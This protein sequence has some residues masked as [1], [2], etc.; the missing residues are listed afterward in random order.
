M[1]P[2]KTY[3]RRKYPHKSHQLLGYLLNWSLYGF[4]I[5]Q[6][7]NY[8]ISFP[9]ERVSHAWTARLVYTIFLLDTTQILMTT[10]H[11]WYALIAG[12]G[13]TRAL[14]DP[15]NS[16]I[17]VPLFTSISMLQECERRTA[18]DKCASL[19]YGTTL[20]RLED[21]AARNLQLDRLPRLVNSPSY[22][23]A[24]PPLYPSR[25]SL[26]VFQAVSGI[27]FAA[28]IQVLSDFSRVREIA[29]TATLWLGSEALCD[30]LITSTVVTFLAVN[31]TGYAQTDSLLS[32]VAKTTVEC[33]LATTGMTS[34]HLVLFLAAES[35]NLH[36]IASIPLSK[37]YSVTLLAMLNA[38]RSTFTLDPQHSKESAIDLEA[39]DPHRLSFG[40]D[41]PI[42]WR[43]GLQTVRVKLSKETL[44]DSGSGGNSPPASAPVHI[45]AIPILPPKPTSPLP[46][47][48]LPTYSNSH[49][50]HSD[51]HGD[52]NAF[53]RER[54][55]RTQANADFDSAFVPVPMKR[56]MSPVRHSHLD[57]GESK[58]ADGAG[59]RFLQKFSKRI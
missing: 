15:G 13:D 42:R 2:P 5:S 35:N 21:Q 52:V 54:P 14:Y 24:Q 45:A 17:A 32:K 59:Q 33:G 40:K 56:P 27:I 57:F 25:S 29:T 6:L 28:Q 20:L 1:Y 7:H 51:A 22:L 26:S 16:W 36:M 47:L 39:V 12:W 23:L 19:L 49:H 11:A 4:E 58:V 50:N 44:R 55:T 41:S 8:H 43:Q 3:F 34:L 48:P 46:A 53:E 31:V 37:V 10:Q 18:A 38:R 9:K 30:L